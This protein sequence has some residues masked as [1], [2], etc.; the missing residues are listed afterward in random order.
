MTLGNL[1]KFRETMK[2]ASKSKKL[3]DKIRRK[4]AAN[5]RKYRARDKELKDML[6][7]VQT[8]QEIVNSNEE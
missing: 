4:I 2:S 7:M 3:E 5:E 8:T 1:I 6:R